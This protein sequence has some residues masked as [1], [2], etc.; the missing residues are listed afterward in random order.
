MAGEPTI[1][2]TSAVDDYEITLKV[3]GNS[4]SVQAPAG[5]PLDV[6][7][8]MLSRAALAYQSHMVATKTIELLAQMSQMRA[9]GIR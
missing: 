7:W 4:V 2:D 5:Q 8:A 1:I 6:T 9:G 3:H